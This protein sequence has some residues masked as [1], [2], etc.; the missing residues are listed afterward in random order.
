MIQNISTVL[1]WMSL[2]SF[3]SAQQFDIPTTLGD[4]GVFDVLVEFLEDADLDESLSSDNGEFS[5]FAPTDDAFALLPTD[6]M[7]CLRESDQS[8]TLAN[9]LLYHVISGTVLAA[10]LG[11]SRTALNSETLTFSISNGITV[12]N[13][14]SNIIFPNEVASNGRIHAIDAGKGM[15]RMTMAGAIRVP[16]DTGAVVLSLTIGFGTVA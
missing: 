8:E 3:V 11:T 12:I 7:D 16:R 13:G 9:L 2:C 15:R 5:L 1:W 14:V 6:F 10:N 4:L